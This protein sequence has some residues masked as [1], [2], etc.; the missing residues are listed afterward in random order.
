MRIGVVVLFSRDD[1]F[2][3]IFCLQSTVF[4]FSFVVSC[5]HQRGAPLFH[6]CLREVGLEAESGLDLRGVALQVEFERQILKPAF[7]LIGFR[8]WV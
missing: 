2:S 7:H 6:T 4:F 8:L 1:S 5:E 3:L